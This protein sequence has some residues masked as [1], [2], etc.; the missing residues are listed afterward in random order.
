MKCFIKIII[1]CALFIAALTGL[2]CLC[3][4]TD[5]MYADLK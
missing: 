3:D 1:T 5:S 2:G 4:K